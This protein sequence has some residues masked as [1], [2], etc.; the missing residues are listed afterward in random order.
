M[1]VDELQGTAAL[2]KVQIQC[3]CVCSFVFMKTFKSS[4][5]TSECPLSSSF[6]ANS[7]KKNFRFSTADIY[8]LQSGSALIKAT[9]GLHAC[10]SVCMCV[11][12]QCK[13]MLS[14]ICCLIE[15]VSFPVQPA[16]QPAFLYRSAP[17]GKW[18]QDCHTLLTKTL[19]E[20]RTQPGTLGQ[21]LSHT[22]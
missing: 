20:I 13:H 10:V 15:T 14:S 19:N 1:K 2:C 6:N 5:E 9:V 11:L 8:D 4:F 7:L 12:L 16:N 18:E 21:S 3:V 17:E 22:L